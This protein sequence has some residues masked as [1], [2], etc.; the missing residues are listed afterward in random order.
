MQEKEI[1][2]SFGKL[3]I[4]QFRDKTLQ[5]SINIMNGKVKAAELK[6]LYSSLEFLTEENK[7][8][9]EYFLQETLTEALF[10]LL[11]SLEEEE[12]EILFEYKNLK[13]NPNLISDGLAGELF[14]EDGWIERFSKFK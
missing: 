4:K 6:Q 1:L 8:T 9:I 5:R 2:D 7:K 14:S 10:N 3:I 12:I 13:Y 11:I